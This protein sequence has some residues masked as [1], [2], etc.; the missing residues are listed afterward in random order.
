M[1]GLRA[2]SVH[3]SSQGRSKIGVMPGFAERTKSWWQKY[4]F[5]WPG[6]ADTDNCGE[7]SGHGQEEKT[8]RGIE[9]ASAR[10]LYYR[11]FQ[12]AVEDG[13]ARVVS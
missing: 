6:K 10:L 11:A 12:F 2:L 4:G 13:N 1:N 5:C 7:V 9:C 8:K 3:C